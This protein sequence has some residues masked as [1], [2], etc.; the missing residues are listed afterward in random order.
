MKD[1]KQIKTYSFIILS[2]WTLVI[3]IS[4]I[5]TISYTNK[6][7]DDLLLNHAKNAFK[8]DMMFRQWV[9]MH[10]G[11]YVTPTEKTPSNPYLSHIPNRDVVT[12]NGMKLTLMNPAYTLRELMN[13]FSGMYGQKGHI[14]S[15]KLLNPNNK[16]DPWEEKVLKEFEKKEITEYYETTTLDDQEHF[17]FMSAMKI[18]QDCLKCHAFQGYKVGDIRGGVSISIPTK[19]YNKRTYLENKNTFFNYL[20]FYIISIII[21]FLCYR[22][23]ISYVQKQQLLDQKLHEKEE[24]LHEQSKMASLGEMLGN[25]AHQWR[26]PLC[27]ISTAAS[28]VKVQKE[29]GKLDDKKLDY[30]MDEI[31]NT[32]KYLS[33]TIDDFRGF[34]TENKKVVTFYINSHLDKIISLMKGSLNYSHIEIIRETPIEY[35]LEGCPNELTQALIN[36]INNAKDAFKEN[37]LEKRYIFLKTK[38][39]GNN[40]IIIIKDTAKG[41]PQNIIN[42]IFEPYFTTK[43]QSQGTGLG[44]YMTYRI[45]TESLKGSI[46]VKNVNFKYKNKKYDGAE[47]TISIP[48]N[49]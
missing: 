19:E 43:H 39:E 6:K 47:F 32:T 21:G 42:K 44:L 46:S 17:R 37:K 5:N 30:T 29:F 13:N 1:L 22:K 14:T 40:L 26:Q 31:I 41:I 34:M 45:I 49:N 38:R 3:L 33:E 24:L 12:T 23:L 27:I 11:V 35:S 36:I 8:K 2:I 7:R 10:G 28:G 25:I 9:T 18:E 4:L 48:L 15:L 16:A 20:L